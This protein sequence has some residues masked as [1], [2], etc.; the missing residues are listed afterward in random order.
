MKIIYKEMF[1]IAKKYSKEAIE[2]KDYI[3]WMIAMTCLKEAY[4]K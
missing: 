2:N 3:L 4:G 1:D